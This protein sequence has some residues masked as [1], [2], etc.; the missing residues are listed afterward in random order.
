MI[1]SKTALVHITNGNINRYKNLGYAVEFN[2]MLD[3]KIEDLQPTTRTSIIIECPECKIEY[4]L[5]WPS[6][7][8]KKTDICKKCACRRVGLQHKILLSPG[9]VFGRLTVISLIEVQQQGSYTRRWQCKCNCGNITN[10]TASKLI[11]GHTQSCGCLHSEVCSEQMKKRPRRV[12]VLNHMWNPN[13]TEADRLDRKYSTKEKRALARKCFVRDQFICKKCGSNKELNAHHIK[14]Y[15]Y[16]DTL[17]LTLE[18]L[19]TLCNP[20]HKQYHHC[21]KLVNVNDVTINEFLEVNV[22]N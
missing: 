19:I 11:A 17:R 20:C 5:A 10:T 9:D 8:R 15:K 1:I 13:L 18:N 14:S 12:G 7:R 2:G 21:Y 22:V 16:N 4:K 6:Y 3:V